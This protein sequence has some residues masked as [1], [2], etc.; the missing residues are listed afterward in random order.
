MTKENDAHS[1]AN[2]EPTADLETATR[3]APAIDN[4]T[5]D[6]ATREI[7]RTEMIAASASEPDDDED[8]ECDEYIDPGYTVIYDRI[9]DAFVH[10]PKNVEPADAAPAEAA[11][12][13]AAPAAEPPP[14]APVPVVPTGTLPLLEAQL[15]EALKIMQDF[16]TWINGPEAPIEKC[17]AVADSFGQLARASAQLGKVAVRLQNGDPE[18]RHRVIVEYADAEGGGVRQ[19]RKRLSHGRG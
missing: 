4:D 17:I 6:D 18:S 13:D 11:P 1:G 7:V 15:G 8:D 19:T 14:T 5:D 3:L 10:V 16:A 9:K 2:P 12:P